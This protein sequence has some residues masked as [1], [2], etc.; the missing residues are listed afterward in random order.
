MQELL[1]NKKLPYA[2]ILLVV[3]NVIWFAVESA[4]GDSEEAYLG[5]L[6]GAQFTPLVMSGQSWRL[7]TALFVHF[8]SSHIYGNMI[9]LLIIGITLERLIGPIRFLVIYLSSGVMAN[10]VTIVIELGM[11]SGDYIVS[12]GASGAIFGIL[13]ALAATAVVDKKKT[14]TSIEP[15]GVIIALV[16]LFFNSMGEGVD[17]GAHFFG[18]IFGFLFGYITRDHDMNGDLDFLQADAP[19]AAKGAYRNPYAN[20]AYAPRQMPGGQPQNL[21]Q[22]PGGQPRNLPPNVIEV[23]GRLYYKTAGNRP[24]MPYLPPVYETPSSYPNLGQYPNPGQYPNQGQSPNPGQY[25]NQGQQRTPIFR[26]RSKKTWIIYVII[27][28]IFILSFLGD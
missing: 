14:F 25:P 11:K 13:G 18:I 24:G 7:F 8:G 1:K 9:A 3:L 26:E 6:Y 12:A 28:I 17:V 27:A 5:I 21:Y 2:T 19:K 16:F 23:N 10:V 22:M 4:H 15:V 20:N